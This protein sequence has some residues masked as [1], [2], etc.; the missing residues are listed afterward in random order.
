MFFLGAN[1]M[2]GKGV[3]RRF[4]RLRSIS[5]EFHRVKAEATAMGRSLSQQMEANNR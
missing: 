4:W 5:R 2:S 1:G 3:S